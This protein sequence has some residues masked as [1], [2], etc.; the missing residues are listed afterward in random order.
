MKKNTAVTVVA[1]ADSWYKVLLPDSSKGFIAVKKL[2]V[3][4]VGKRFSSGAQL[5]YDRPFEGSPI[6]AVVEDG[7]VFSIDGQ[8]GHYWRVRYDSL[9][10]WVFMDNVFSR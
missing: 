1:A 8:W 5:L 6:K 4:P 7:T 9:Y 3:S 10:G 2:T